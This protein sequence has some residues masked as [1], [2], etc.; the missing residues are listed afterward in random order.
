MDDSIDSGNFS[1]T[2]Y[3]SLIRKDS[4][5]HMHILA[6]YGKE[7]LPFARNLKTLEN[8]TDSYLYFRLSLLHS[9]LYFFFLYRSPSSSLGKVFNSISSII[10]EVLSINPPATVFVFFDFN[11]RHKDWLTFSAGTDRTGEL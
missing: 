7:R 5:T 2:S 8:S 4:I 9:V 3:L 10:D 6:I 11:V 1:V